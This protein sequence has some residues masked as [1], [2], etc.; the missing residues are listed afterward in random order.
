MFWSSTKPSNEDPAS[1][2][3]LHSHR[4]RSKEM[5][6]RRRTKVAILEPAIQ[7]RTMTSHC[8]SKTPRCAV[9]HITSPWPYTLQHLAGEKTCPTY[10]YSR[11]IEKCVTLLI[12]RPHALRIG[13]QIHIIHININI[14][15]FNQSGD[16]MTIVSCPTPL[17]LNAFEICTNAHH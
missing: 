5:S 7:F 2:P 10:L 11:H 3:K 15:W 14:R 16:V 8:L 13:S 1:H 4:G 12:S 6:R 9:S 17:P